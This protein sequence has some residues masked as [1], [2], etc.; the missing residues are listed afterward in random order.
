P[1]KKDWGPRD[2]VHKLSTVKGV[3]GGV[4]ATHD[5]LMVAGAL[6]AP[7]KP[8]MVAAFMPQILSRMNAWG[9]ALQVGEEVTTMTIT[10]GKVP[11]Q[12]SKLG[13]I[14]FAVM[15]RICKS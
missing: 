10:F 5:G 11:W 6:P 13:K 4:I 9:K 8:D 3:S 14:Y 1:E 15:G 2:V 7:L 12:I